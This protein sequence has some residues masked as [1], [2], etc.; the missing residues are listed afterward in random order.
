LVAAIFASL[1]RAGLVIGLTAATAT[2]WML[3]RPNRQRGMPARSSLLWAL[4]PLLVILALAVGGLDWLSRFDAAQLEAS[5]RERE[6]NRLAAWAAAQQ[7]WPWGSGLGTFSSAFTPYQAPA[8]EQFVEHAHNDYV[9]WLLEIGLIF[10][11]VLLMALAL[12]GRRL[13]QLIKGQD[14]HSAT[15]H[16]ALAS[17]MGL[18]AVALHAWVDFPLR[19]PA[20]AVLAAFL[21]GVFLREPANRGA[22]KSSGLPSAAGGEPD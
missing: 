6:I 7:Y 14:R 22:R 21:L 20:N 1:S 3:W 11:L 10:P 9:Q 2:G 5:A 13:I 16:L 4:V 17:A 8:I 15:G 18:L 19:I 12:I